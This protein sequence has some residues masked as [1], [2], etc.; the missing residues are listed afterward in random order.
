MLVE[1][2]ALLQNNTWELV[3]RPA[4]VN[5]VSFATNSIS[6]ALSHATK[7]DGL[8]MVSRNNQV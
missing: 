6:I 3:P 2:D 7:Q 1:F 8:S 4:D 5:E